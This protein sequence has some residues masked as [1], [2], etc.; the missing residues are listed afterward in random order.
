MAGWKGGLGTQMCSDCG[1]GS[2]RHLESG[3]AEGGK[4][5]CFAD[6]ELIRRGRVAGCLGRL[7]VG[8]M[9]CWFE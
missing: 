8:R 6:T 5:T 4:A 3:R 9:L 7:A 2:L 1:L